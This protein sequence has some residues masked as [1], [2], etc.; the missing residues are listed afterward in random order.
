M[1]GYPFASDNAHTPTPSSVGHGIWNYGYRFSE[2]ET[3]LPESKRIKFPNKNDQA[4]QLAF[5]KEG[6]AASHGPINW[7]IIYHLFSCR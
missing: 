6:V 2:Q 5:G 4:P 1:K 7:D 3:R